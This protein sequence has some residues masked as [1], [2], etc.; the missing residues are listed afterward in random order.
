MLTVY[1]FNLIVYSPLVYCTISFHT[2]HKIAFCISLHTESFRLFSVKD[3]EV[4]LCDFTI[5]SGSL[6][7]SRVKGMIFW[8][9][10]ND[11]N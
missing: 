3:A 2:I 6:I 9:Y 10:C 8:N 11:G 5:C 1:F 7:A 4:Q